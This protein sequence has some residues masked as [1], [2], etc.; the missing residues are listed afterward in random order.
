MIRHARLL[1]ALIRTCLVRELTFRASFVASLIS[2]IGWSLIMLVFLT[3]VVGRVENLAGWELRDV[4]VLCGTFMVV[5]GITQ[6][7]FEVN[8]W[9]MPRYVREGTLD[10]LITKPVDS[11]FY[12]SCRY[13]RFSALGLLIPGIALIATGAR[14]PFVAVDLLLY[15]A[16]ALAG[17]FILYSVSFFLATWTIWF[18]R[19]ELGGLIYGLFDVI[20]F[21][22]DIYPRAL[23]AV[24]TYGLPLVFIASVPTQTLQHRGSLWGSLAGVLAA[25][26]AFLVA[27]LFW[28]FALRFYASTGS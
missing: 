3:A 15:L 9:S 13:L 27:R 28:R 23:R 1:L 5:Q 22:A 4:Y 11:Q 7:L 20:R 21:P 17:I 12:V 6:F 10:L 26:L 18:V 24:F 2:S 19:A 25:A 16:G 14:P 8:M